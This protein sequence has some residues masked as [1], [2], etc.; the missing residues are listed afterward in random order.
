[1]ARLSAALRVE[2]SRD[3]LGV[4]AKVRQ[5]LSV[6]F[7]ISHRGASCKYDEYENEK[8]KMNV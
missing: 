8:P 5:A 1:M 6:L 7:P 3:S 2:S 4:P